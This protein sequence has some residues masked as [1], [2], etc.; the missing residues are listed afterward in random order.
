MQRRIPRHHLAH[1][2]KIILVDR[3]LQLPDLVEGLNVRLEL[4]PTR[5]S[6]LARA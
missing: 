4:R 3:R 2:R 6:V 1:E 5:K